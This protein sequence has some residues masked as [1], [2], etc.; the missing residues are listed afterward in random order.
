MEKLKLT[1]FGHL[2]L[3]NG[4]EVLD[5][6]KIRS[7]KMLQMLV[8]LLIYRESPLT[9]RR[10]IEVFWGDEVR[11]DPD[12][13]L[14]NLM[15][16]LRMELRVLGDG[17]FI[18]TLQEAYQ[19]NPEIIVETDYEKFEKMI[20]E[21]RRTTGP[22]AK[23]ERRRLGREIIECYQGNITSRVSGEPWII[24]KV[25]WYW[26]GYMDA[27]RVLG[28]L[29]EQ[30]E[31]WESLELLCRQA[32]EE[33]PAEEDIHCWM[34]L[35]LWGREKYDLIPQY[36]E[37]VSRYFYESM[38]IFSPEKL[39][40]LYHNIL[41]ETEKEAESIGKVAEKI[42]EQSSP[43]GVFF[44]SYQTFCQIYRLD[45]RRIS[46]LKISSYLVLLTLRRTGRRKQTKRET[47]KKEMKILEEILREHLRRGDVVTQYSQNQ[48]IIILSMISLEG[49]IS[50]IQ[51]LK[52]I[53]RKCIG[54]R[55]L[56]L[57]YELCEIEP[58]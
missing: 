33:N 15:S 6:E 39:T 37:K 11:K 38:G 22:G 51:R 17:P 46:R 8:Y 27:V 55:H 54:P 49:C 56:E 52:K 10:L 19:W 35:S 41:P 30:E 47:V 44:C 25:T 16:R 3:S 45:A 26:S 5:E 50:V 36:Y 58:I 32:L 13:A 24:P 20:L 21:L 1:L 23:Q 4:K 34:L 18:C 14:R 28:E 2:S 40:A 48:F 7:N 9:H 57:W 43:E 53:F 12:V 29:Y 42:I 31:D